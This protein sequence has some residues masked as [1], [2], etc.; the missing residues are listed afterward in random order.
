L[1]FYGILP[2]HTNHVIRVMRSHRPKVLQQPTLP[3]GERP[4]EYA[5]PRIQEVDLKR[6][7]GTAGDVEGVLQAQFSQVPS[8]SMLVHP[9]LVFKGATS[10]H[11]AFQ[12]YQFLLSTCLDVSASTS[13][14]QRWLKLLQFCAPD[15]QLPSFVKALVSH[16]PSAVAV[17]ELASATSVKLFSSSPHPIPRRDI[18]SCLNRALASLLQRTFTIFTSFVDGKCLESECQDCVQLL[19][20]VLD[21]SMN[22]LKHAI[23]KVW[24]F[25]VVLCDAVLLALASNYSDAFNCFMR[26]HDGLRESDQ[27]ESIELALLGVSSCNAAYCLL[28]LKASGEADASSSTVTALL[29]MLSAD[30][31]MAARMVPAFEAL[32]VSMFHNLA[33]IAIRNGEY[34][35]AFCAWGEVYRNLETAAAHSGSSVK[36]A[37]ESL[38]TADSGLLNSSLLCVG[39]ALSEWKSAQEMISSSECRCVADLH[40]CLLI[41]L[42]HLRF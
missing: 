18:V 26:V 39:N 24:K 1:G 37:L 2:A 9:W 36:E 31:R 42:T 22:S 11:S 30:A 15:G 16:A 33:L 19:R 41:V 40:F 29:Q 7:H 3:E 17:D 32:R 12:D 21:G 5:P 14:Q 34:F 8:D 13:S 10:T 28:H 23:S 4:L 20:D 35:R 27:S 38:A 25:V 6:L